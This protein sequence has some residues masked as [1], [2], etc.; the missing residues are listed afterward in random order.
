MPPKYNELIKVEL[1]R[2]LRAGVVT[3]A[4][5]ARSFPVFS[6]TKKD[7]DPRF[8]VDYQVLIRKG[9]TD[10]FLLPKTQEN[11]DK[12]AGSVYFTTPYFF[13]GYCQIR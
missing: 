6:A 3:S 11:F 2:I 8:G 5:S 4:T 1:E 12:L 9:K 7:G 13:S 10:Y